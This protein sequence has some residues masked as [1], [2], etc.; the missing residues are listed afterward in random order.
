MSIMAL[1]GPSCHLTPLLEPFIK[2]CNGIAKNTPLY[3]SRLVLRL[4]RDLVRPFFTLKAQQCSISLSMIA[5]CKLLRSCNVGRSQPAIASLIKEL[6]RPFVLHLWC[7]SK[8][9]LLLHG[10][11]LVKRVREANVSPQKIIHTLHE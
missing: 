3:L 11:Y 5:A 8:K 10:F 9:V 4:V 7:K 6:L 1:G 2:T